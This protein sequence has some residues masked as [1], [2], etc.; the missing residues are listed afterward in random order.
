MPDDET[1]VF[2]P[3]L[4]EGYKKAH[5][6]VKCNVIAG[7]Q[8]VAK[9]TIMAEDG[10]GVNHLLEGQ[11]DEIRPVEGHPNLKFVRIG[12]DWYLQGPCPITVEKSIFSSWPREASPT[13]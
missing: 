5:L 6:S 11:P 10:A 7:S 3:K 12:K 1:I 9:I 13:K 2:N 8:L 4:P